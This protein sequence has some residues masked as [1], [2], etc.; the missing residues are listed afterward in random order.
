ML[1]H[2]KSVAFGFSAAVVGV[3]LMW[4]AQMVYTDH[5]RMN[6]VWQLEIDRANQQKVAG[7]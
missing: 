1:T 2:W 6:A 4:L 7:K 5:Q 3:L